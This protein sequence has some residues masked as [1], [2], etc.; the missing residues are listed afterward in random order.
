M[1][2]IS[3]KYGEFV[4]GVNFTEEAFADDRCAVFLSDLF[5]S[6]KKQIAEIINERY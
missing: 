4:D 6:W 2:N 1:I 5:L 3:I